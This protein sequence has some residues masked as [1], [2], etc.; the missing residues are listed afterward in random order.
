MSEQVFFFC[1]CSDGRL[2]FEKKTINYN[3]WTFNSKRQYYSISKLLLQ[4]Q[5]KGVV[6]L[7]H[8]S[9][10]LMTIWVN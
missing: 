6:Y 8:V 7:L 2:I 10:W 1:E 4:G 5:G 9:Q 3:I